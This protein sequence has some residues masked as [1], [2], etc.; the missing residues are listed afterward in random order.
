MGNSNLGPNSSLEPIVAINGREVEGADEWASQLHSVEERFANLRLRAAQNLP[1]LGKLLPDILQDFQTTIEEL[2]IAE[3]EL[4][5]QND[6]LAIATETAVG[7][8]RR[9]QELFDFAPDGYV[10]LDARGVVRDANRAALS[11]LQMQQ[12]FLTGK[13]FLLFIAKE[14]RAAFQHLLGRLQTEDEIRGVEIHIVPREGRSLP[15]A[16]FLAAARDEQGRLS[17]LRCL[18]H[19]LSS[20]QE[21]QQRLLHAERLAAIGQTVTTLAHEGRNALQRMQACLSMLALEVQDRPHALELLGRLQKAQDSLAYLFEDIREYAAPF[22]LERR[23][24]KLS[25]IWREAWSH[26][27]PLWKHRD[28]ALHEATGNL[29]LHCVADPFRLEQVFR[30]ILDNA[31]AACPDPVRITLSVSETPLNGREAWWISLRDNGPGIPPEQREQ[32]F[33]PFFTTKARG[34][35]LGMSI[36]RRIVEAHGGQIKVCDTPDSSSSVPGQK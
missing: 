4:R 9:Y 6:L 21:A 26:L 28:V 12:R 29:D 33:E 20:L 16:L 18:L 25:T 34:T 15:M 11:L 8:H 1:Q 36:A 5:R 24:C 32:V 30:N 27:E 14:D 13:P 3:E 7:E 23:S 35:G 10:V 22:K 2:R 17:S 19:D 31:L